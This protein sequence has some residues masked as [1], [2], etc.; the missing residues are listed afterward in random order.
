M[1]NRKKDKNT[2]IVTRPAK[3]AKTLKP[4]LEKLG[5]L[6]FE[7]PS[8]TT[9][10]I[11]PNDTIKEALQSLASFDWI[12]FTSKRGVQAFFKHIN[13][14]LSSQDILAKIQIAAV[15]PRTS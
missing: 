7:L 5:Y 14:L 9:N 1:T 12:I 3:E 13:M 6:V 8:I 10:D 15:G 4:K 11:L 2:I